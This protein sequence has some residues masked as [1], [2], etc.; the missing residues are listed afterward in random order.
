[1]TAVASAL[2]AAHE[3]GLV[4]RDVKP[5]NILLS[6]EGDHEHVYLTDFGLTKRLGSP[7]S[8]TRTGAWVGTP[9]YV[10]PEQIRAGDGRRPRRHLLA[11][12][13][14]LRDAHR[15]GRVPEG[16]RHGEALGARPGSMSAAQRKR[17][18]LVQAFDDIVARATAKEPDDRFARASDLAAAVDAA[19]A[20]QRAYIGPAALQVTRVAPTASEDHDVFV[21]EPTPGG[22]SGAAASD[23]DAVA[24]RVRPAVAPAPRRRP[25][26]HR[27][28]LP[29]QGRAAVAASARA[30]VAR[31]GQ[32]SRIAV[33]LGPWR[34]RRGA[35]AIARRRQLARRRRRSSPPPSSRRT[36]NW[37]PIADAAVPAPVRGIDGRRRQDLRVRRHRHHGLELPPPRSSTRRPTAGRPDPACPCR[38]TTSRP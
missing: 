32:R 17:P 10:A 26:H 29:P 14:A 30:G 15:G 7:G 24:H 13:R 12:L 3:R 6:G 25:A 2:D 23:P 22:R 36:S 5:A 27:R 20:E 4:H 28:T 35:A 21:A 34:D 37:Q 11:R 38:C 9:D 1:M 16:Q 19:I 33:A 31:S 18:E 8:L